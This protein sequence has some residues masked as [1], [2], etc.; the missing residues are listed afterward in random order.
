MGRNMARTISK[1]S[2]VKA[3]KSYT[4][5]AE[6]VA[7]LESL[8]RQRRGASTSSVLEEILQQVRR[9]SK[10]MAL[11]KAV[12]DYYSSLGKKELDEQTK[13][14]EFAWAEFSNASE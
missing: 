1:R 7:Y 11:E 9:A 2:R 6:S 3:K 12:T 8:R 13:W 14:T 10:K 5:S 4:L